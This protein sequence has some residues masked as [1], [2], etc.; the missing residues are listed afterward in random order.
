MNSQSTIADS[1][2]V[3]LLRR[4]RDQLDGQN[5]ILLAR[6]NELH[7][8]NGVMRKALAG[9]VGVDSVLELGAVR[10]VLGEMPDSDERKVALAAVE[11]LLA[12]HP[13][14]PKETTPA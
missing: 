1:Q 8:Q 9:L 11:A 7:A 10:L 14:R 2:T 4:E 12:T 3:D 5:R 13:D 6:T